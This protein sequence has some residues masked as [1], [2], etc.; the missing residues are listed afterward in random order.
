MLD[1]PSP[2]ADVIVLH[3]YQ[4]SAFMAVFKTILYPV[5]AAFAAAGLL[6]MG[7]NGGLAL[8]F[9]IAIPAASLPV[10]T[11]VGLLVAANRT[12]TL[13]ADDKVITRT[14]L[15]R[16]T[17]CPRADLEAI[18]YGTPLRGGLECEF[19]LRGGRTA[20]RI[21]LAPWA[22]LGN[23]LKAFAERLRVPLRPNPRARRF[24][25]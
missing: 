11:L 13:Q 1:E 24:R 16:T 22:V 15:G 14:R 18:E 19:R 6:V 3:P 8:V 2:N 21:T 23:E 12:T 4:W 10:A 20:F 17:S 5:L 25:L 9:L 7:G